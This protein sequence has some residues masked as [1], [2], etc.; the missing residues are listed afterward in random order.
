ME[1]LSFEETVGLRRAEGGGG[2]ALH[3]AVS[4][5]EAGTL[6]QAG[7]GIGGDVSIVFVGPSSDLFCSGEARNVFFHLPR[8][9]CMKFKLINSYYLLMPIR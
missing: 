6:K 7:E 8:L 1:S 4:Q 2:A 5:C 3:L 9:I